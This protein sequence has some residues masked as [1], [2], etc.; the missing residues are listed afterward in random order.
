MSCSEV[1]P[2][3]HICNDTYAL[4]NG[5]L[6]DFV[7]NCT[8]SLPLP[9]NTRSIRIP[10][11]DD[12]FDSL[13]LFQIL[14]D[15]SVLH[16]IHEALFA[17]QRILVHCQAGAQRSP[18]VVACYMIKFHGMTVSEV[19]A[20]IKRKRPQAFS[21]TPTFIRTLNMMYAYVFACIHH[22]PAI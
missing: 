7:V 10:I 20:F 19:I 12:P 22:L 11:Q 21:W 17:G 1:F 8:L 15:T 14:R 3:L 4:K 18:T 2:N 6:Y 16:D 13:P 5:N 9:E